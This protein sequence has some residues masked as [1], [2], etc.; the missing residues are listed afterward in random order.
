VLSHRQ[1]THVGKAAEK[2]AS[3]RPLKDI[4]VAAQ[5]YRSVHLTSTNLRYVGL[6]RRVMWSGEIGLQLLSLSD[7]LITDQNK[8]TNNT[9]KQ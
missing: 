8:Q 7:A 5:Y 2:F 3:H 1:P 4:P 6:V 9:S